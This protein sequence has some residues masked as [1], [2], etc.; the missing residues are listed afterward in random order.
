LEK[1][2]VLLIILIVSSIGLAV[3]LFLVALNSEPTVSPL[4]LLAQ[5]VTVGMPAEVPFFIP[6]A[7]LQFLI[8]VLAS[9][10]GV[11]YFLVLP[12]IRSYTAPNPKQ[13]IGGAVGM[14]MK[15][16]NLEEQK[17]VEILRIHNG[18]YLQKY[19][20]KESELSKLKTHRIV[21]RLSE[22]GLVQ[23]T[24]KGNTNEVSLADWFFNAMKE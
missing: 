10:V 20:T 9:V 21:A 13:P 5:I 17:V 1:L 15:T 2:K 8:T 3:S 23:V 24:K 12:E 14:V 22:R 19:I 18:K 16:L 4:E 11:I 7:T 6:L